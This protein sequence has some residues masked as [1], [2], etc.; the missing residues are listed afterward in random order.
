MF[1]AQP[2]WMKFLGK[3]SLVGLSVCVIQIKRVGGGEPGPGRLRPPLVLHARTAKRF[4]ISAPPRV[5]KE[6]GRGGG[7]GAVICG[8]QTDLGDRG[9]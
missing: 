5:G 8:R 1:D 9:V 4:R 3:G 6:V 7:H 2:H